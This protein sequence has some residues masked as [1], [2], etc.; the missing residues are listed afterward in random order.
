MIE[1]ILTGGGAAA[2]V[3]A[4][5]YA[6]RLALDAWKERR[7]EPRVA[8][9][10]AVT[11]AATA[12]S[13]LLASLQEERVE[14]QRLSG[15]VQELETQN[16]LLYEKIRD[17]RREYEAEISAMRKQLTD[18]SDRLLALQKRL[19]DERAD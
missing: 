15:R 3:I 11:D 18:V 17:Q 19:S 14:V 5:A 9:T 16:A 12:N 10:T 4:V 1:T 13:L 6:G 8:T 2:F 7:G